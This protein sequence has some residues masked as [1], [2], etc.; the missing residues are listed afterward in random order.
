M[1]ARDGIFDN[2]WIVGR[3][4]S[5]DEP[6]LR[7]FCLPHAGGGASLFRGWADALP[8]EVEVCPIQLPGRENRLR[9]PLSTRLIPL[10]ETL[11]AALRPCLDRPFAL[12]GHSMGA[13]IA[14]VLA[15][16]LSRR[17]RV[18]PA[19]L[20]VSGRRAPHLAAREA[21]IHALPDDQFIMALQDRYNSLP[22][23]ILREPELLEIYLPI[24]R[25]DMAMVETFAY[26]PDVMLACPIAA[27][28]GTED[29]LVA[30]D[31]LSAWREH[32]T[33]SFTL[34]LFEGGHFFVQTARPALLS[35]VSRI[36]GGTAS[37]SAL[38]SRGS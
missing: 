27:F 9:E 18:A 19:Y 24:V 15:H 14:F 17:Y 36:L 29:R 35:A 32:T 20:F 2:P 1:N 31:E 21:P 25:A 28:G 34:K 38:G 33:G 4:R 7:L 10:A 12:F 13:W 16:E 22:D 6:R 37:G 5:S 3:Q 23:A 30:R 8:P 11:A 26:A